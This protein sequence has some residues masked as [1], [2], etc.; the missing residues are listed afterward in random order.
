MKGA[1][2]GHFELAGSTIILLFEP[3]T[4]NLKDE[5][6]AELLHQEEVRV[7]QGQWIGNALN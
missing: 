5:I 1:E 7:L 4:I 3:G 2:K 6:S